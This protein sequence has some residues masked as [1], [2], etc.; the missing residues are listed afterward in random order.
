MDR[1]SSY[2]DGQI[3]NTRQ[4][5]KHIERPLSLIVHVNNG[6]QLRGNT[7]PVVYNYDKI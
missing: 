3:V 1:H 5:D 6:T 4:T 2:T 7:G